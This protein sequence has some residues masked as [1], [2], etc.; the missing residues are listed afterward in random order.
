MGTKFLY[1]C[2][3]LILHKTSA[4]VE[5]SFS[6]GYRVFTKIYNQCDNSEDIIKCF[7]VQALKAIERALKVENFNIMSGIQIIRNKGARSLMTN[8]ILT[9]DKL[10]SLESSQINGALFNAVSRFLSSHKIQ[11]DIPKL[12]EEARMKGGSGGGGGGG[13]GGMKGKYNHSI[14]QSQK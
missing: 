12:V 5:S 2:L 13:G 11:L 10:Q 4:D 3:V 9:D 14:L 6:S 1:L 8:E 7:K